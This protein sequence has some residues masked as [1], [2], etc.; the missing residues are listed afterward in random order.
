VA[1][2]PTRQVAGSL[3]GTAWTNGSNSR[4]RP[5]ARSCSLAGAMAEEDRRTN[6]RHIACFPAHVEVPE[7]DHTQIALIR[8]VSVDGALLLT[9]SVYEVGKEL[10]LKLFLSGDA[11]VDPHDATA[12]V[13]RSGRRDVERADL[14]PFDAAVTFGEP[15]ENLED[16]IKQLAKRQSGMFGKI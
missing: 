4:E 11:S 10:S 5:G 14:W 9:R 3:P 6:T 15:L 1:Q 16:E 12:V 7:N 13:V 8:N 2:G